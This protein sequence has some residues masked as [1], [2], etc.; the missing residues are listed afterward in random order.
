MDVKKFLSLV[1]KALPESPSPVSATATLRYELGQINSV[2]ELL[3]IMVGSPLISWDA[4]LEAYPDV[5]VSGIHPAV[6]FFRHGIHESRKLFV[7]VTKKVPKVSVV[8]PNYNNG[9]FIAK[10][11]HSLMNQTLQEIEI[12]VVDDGSTDDSVDIVKRLAKKDL[13]IRLELLGRNMSQ[14][15]ARKKGVEC[16]KGETIMFLDPDDF[17]APD[18]CEKAYKAI[19]EG[20]DI[21]CFN[22]RCIKPGAPDRGFQ[23]SMTNYA[24]RG[25]PG[26]LRGLEILRA[27]LVRG[28]LSDLL[29]NKIYRAGICK[30]AFAEMADGFFPRG[31]DWY[32]AIVLMHKASSL[33]H[34]PDILY[35]Y[36]IGEGISNADITPQKLTA[37]LYSGDLVKPMRDYICRHKLEEFSQHILPWMMRK[38]IDA[39][40][41][42]VPQD[43]AGAYFARMAEQ[44]GLV[45]LLALLV[46]HYSQHVDKI[47][48]LLSYTFPN[49]PNFATIKH[50]GLIID[51]IGNGGAEN[52]VILI[53][54]LLV[55][56]GFKVSCFVLLSHKNESNLPYG[57]KVFHVGKRPDKPE[58]KLTRIRL[59]NYYLQSEN[60]DL[61]MHHALWNNFAIWDFILCRTMGI[62]II[63]VRHS[64][65][66][67]SLLKPD[68]H[69]D[70]KQHISALLLADK[71]ICLCRYGE[72][73]YR[74]MGIDAKYIHNP[75]VI[76][77]AKIPQF[78]RRNN[79]VIVVGR[80]SDPVKNV[81]ECLKI[82]YLLARQKE[83]IKMIFI[84]SFEKRETE[85]QFYKL[86]KAY[87]IE[88]N[89]EVTGWIK[90]TQPLLNGAAVL[91]STSFTEGFPLSIS[92]AQERGLPCVIYDL[93]IMAAKGNESII[94]V[95][96]GNAVKA[97]NEILA[98]LSDEKK[99]NHLS[100]IARKEAARYS[101]E[102]YND[103]LMKLL[104]TFHRESDYTSYTPEEYAT[105][106]RTLSFY[107]TQKAPL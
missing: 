56:H 75:V 88:N 55:K 77:D 42:Y 105:V 48:S 90:N 102:S 49:R 103:K 34:I 20:D 57:V 86:V 81:F 11:L 33:T 79:T 35:Y 74:L 16:A 58:G 89:I 72:L 12:I 94:R 78:H 80:L 47:A 76:Q 2:A 13:R 25:Q 70:L 39:W 36:R 83:S 44:Y 67:R 9:L 45:D 27:A 3:T 65:Y 10:A 41:K 19:L 24:N 53:C 7:K 32:E 29:W 46:T 71:V 96:Q 28:K 97:A 14:H 15:T 82:A 68:P 38:P 101:I 69:I 87:K 62:P 98:L 18:A 43:M 99:W 52:A 37:F 85:E 26:R 107:S 5:A 50:I 61:V 8:V 100:Q 95:P 23:E 92:E 30:A 73:F 64:A 104:N 31:Q 54:R 21:V 60:V 6:H 63:G 59:L 84:G 1:F 4:Y 106:I 40:L 51:R 66:Y 22:T 91:L 17:Y 93:P